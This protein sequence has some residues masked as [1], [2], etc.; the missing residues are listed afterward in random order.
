M[1]KQIYCARCG[2]ELHFAIKALKSVQQTITVVEPHTCSEETADNP[3]TDNK[4]ELILKPKVSPKDGKI[5]AMF[6]DLE[7]SSKIGGKNSLPTTTI[8]D[9]ADSKGD[10]RPSDIIREDSTKVDSLAPKGILGSLKSLIPSTPENEL[11]DI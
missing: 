8:F 9:D 6:E 4:N 7:F 2:T 11:K 1:T 10:K 5:N 3:F